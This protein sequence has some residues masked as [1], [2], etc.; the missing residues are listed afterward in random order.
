ML[1]SKHFNK[2]SI[3]KDYLTKKSGRSAYF[4]KYFKGYINSD[5]KH[6]AT[7]KI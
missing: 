6:P 2:F 4:K 3:Y 1:P 5:L 7:V